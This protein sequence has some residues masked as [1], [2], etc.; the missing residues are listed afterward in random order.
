M[1]ASVVVLAQP[2]DIL[3]KLPDAAQLSRMPPFCQL[4]PVQLQ[5]TLDLAEVRRIAGGAVVFEEGQPVRQ[6]HLLL[7]GHIRFLRLTDEGDQII[8][9]HIPAGQM[10]GI[11]VALGQVTH[12]VT[13]ISANDCVVFSWPNACWP[14]FCDAYDGFAAE[15][16]RAFGARSGEMSNRI[17]ELSTK[18][19]EQRVACAL[20]RMI[21]QSGRKVAG[22]IEIGFPISRQ[23]IADMT[24]A[25][26]HT[27]SRM[28]SV[29]ERLGIVKSA[30]CLIVVTDPHQLVM[31]SGMANGDEIDGP[32]A[33]LPAR[34]ANAA[35]TAA[36]NSARKIASSSRYSAQASTTV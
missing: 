16:F 26:L 34:Y 31:I 12:Q 32:T 35:N 36:R 11:G 1:D 28:L 24:G 29:W 25:T 9:L 5:N 30:R 22:G 33:I 19:V 13:S 3:M 15:A 14:V 21:A 17:V 18:L 27:V 8:V 10:F 6:F 23:N 7:S 2:Q 20:L 4:G